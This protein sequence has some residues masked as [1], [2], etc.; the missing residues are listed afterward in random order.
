MPLTRFQRKADV[1][2][3]LRELQKNGFCVWS[4]TLAKKSA[5]T[6]AT[7]QTFSM[8]TDATVSRMGVFPPAAGLQGQAPNHPML[9]CLRGTV[10]NDGE[11]VD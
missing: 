10:V 3:Q 7:T 5:S 2:P 8:N 1:G 4:A 6:C 9:L 11:K